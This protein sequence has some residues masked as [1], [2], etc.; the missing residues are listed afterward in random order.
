[1]AVVMFLLG[2][3]VGYVLAA[4]TIQIVDDILERL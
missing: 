4:I 3:L 1:M 2:V